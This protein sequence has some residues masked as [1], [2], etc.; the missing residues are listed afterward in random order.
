MLKG[1]NEQQRDAVTEQGSVLLTACPGSGKTRAL[2]YKIAYELERLTSPK[3]IIVAV[4]FTNRA[5]DEI[6]KRIRDLNAD[7]TNLWAGTIH[8]FCLE[9]IL[10]PYMCYLRELKN[11]FSISDEYNSESLISELKIKYNISF[12]D[13]VSTRYLASGEKEEIINR[14]L[15]DDYHELLMIDK[16]IDFDQIL[17]YSYK[18]LSSFPKISETLKNMFQLICVDEYQ[19]TQ[20]LQYAILAKI[21]HGKTGKCKMFIVGDAD[22]AIY[23]SLGGVAKTHK[24]I[25]LE[26]STAF[27]KR[28]LS[29]NYRSNQ[30][31]IDYYRNFQTSDI[32]I[33]ALGV[34]AN[35]SAIITYNKAIHKDELVKYIVKIIGDK[36]S[37][38][39]PE[40][41][42]CVLAPTWYLVIPM[43]RKLKSLM[44]SV[45]FDAVGL[46]PLLKN[47]E[48]VWFKIARLFLVSPSPKS[49]LTRKRWATELINEL[50]DFG[51][52]LFEDTPHKSKA[53]LKLTNTISSNENDGLAYLKECFINLFKQLEVDIDYNDH[54]KIHW[55]TFFQGAEKRLENPDFDLA[56]DIESFKKMFKHEEG[57][58]VNTCHGIKGEEFDT[59]ISFGLL[60]GKLPN[61]NETTPKAAEKLLYVI[62]SRAKRE[63]H[64]I[65]ET[66]RVT[67]S[68]RPYNPTAQ[69]NAVTY[70]YD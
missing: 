63:L 65:S 55:E 47:K 7:D 64:L 60:H 19:D 58:V 29:G 24:E 31:L 43:G 48:N 12:W 54:L 49:Y 61:W 9:W 28:E 32:D 5:A 62:C 13:S 2:T 11:G 42:I 67:G 35:D 38:G 3:K 44:P 53:L 50:N 70:D 18:L 10:R 68:R 6:K 69:L 20:E 52:L 30:Q 56:K 22:Q 46:S 15:I 26:F 33:K 23:G 39:I 4:T 37:E 59:V 8:S 36:I 51:V 17:H 16:L 1:L 27:I 25:Q 41:E 45:N 21:M 34:N 40:H 57:V 66:G 14:A